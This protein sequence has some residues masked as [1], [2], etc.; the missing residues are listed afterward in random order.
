MEEGCAVERNSSQMASDN[1]NEL[2]NEEVAFN[3][4]A[5]MA[6]LEFLEAKFPGAKEEVFSIGRRILEERG[7]QGGSDRSHE[8]A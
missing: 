8:D 5:I 3:L 4:A 7:I 6:I 1:R 2:L